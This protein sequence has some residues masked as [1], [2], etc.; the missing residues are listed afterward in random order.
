MNPPRPKSEANPT[1]FADAPYKIRRACYHSEGTET[2][3]SPAK[4]K[5]PRNAVPAFVWLASS[6][7]Q[8]ER[9]NDM[10]GDPALLAKMAFLDAEALMAEWEYR[11]EDTVSL[12]AGGAH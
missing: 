8:V 5:A 2:S 6:M 3:P 10:E 1:E 11:W 9:R 7:M 12:K 4:L